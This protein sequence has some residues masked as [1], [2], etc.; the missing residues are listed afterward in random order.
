MQE[1][2]WTLV[3][4]T[5]K[6]KSRC[7]DGR[8]VEARHVY[9]D[10]ILNDGKIHQ[11]EQDFNSLQ[12]KIT[13]DFCS[14]YFMMHYT[15]QHV[16]IMIR[17]VIDSE[18]SQEKHEKLN[19]IVSCLFAYL[20]TDEMTNSEYCLMTKEWLNK[21]AEVILNSKHPE[22]RLYLLNHVLRCCGGISSWATGF[23][24]CPNP[25]EDSDY[26][27]ALQSLNTCLVMLKTILTPVK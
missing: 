22:A 23:V 12:S 2:I 26:D 1:S 24:Q 6:D 15:Q 20:R 11:L 14:N 27:D 18:E 19:V 4:K 25:L 21:T 13:R 8:L 9:Q 16:Q 3:N 10:A 7:N 17:S 5:I